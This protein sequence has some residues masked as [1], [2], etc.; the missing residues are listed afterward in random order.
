MHDGPS[1]PGAS[2]MYIGLDL[3]TTNIKALLLD[4]TGKCLAEADAPVSLRTPAAD[5]VEQDMSEIVEGAFR[6]L[7]ACGK[8]AA[9]KVKA[10]GVS[11]QGGA[12][13][14]VDGD[15]RPAGPVIGWMDSRAASWEEALT[16]ELGP[17]WF[18]VHT[19]H[20]RARGAVGQILRLRSRSPGL[21][22]PPNGLGFVGD[23]AVQ[24]L[25]G[26]R[27][28]D[29]TSLSIAGLCNPALRDVD[30]DLLQK[31]GLVPDR[32]PRL[33][34]A[35][36]PAG[37]LTRRAAA[38]TGLVE[39]TPVL[40]A[41][42][43]QYAAAV[44]AGVLDPGDV[45]VGAGTAWVLLAVT[46]RPGTPAAG[47]ALVGP[48][49]LP[50][51][52]GQMLAPG[53]GGASLEW[54]LRLVGAGRMSADELDARLER[55]PP[56]SDGVRVV[57]LFSPIVPPGLSPDIRGCIDG[58]RLYHGADHLLRAV[59]E[60]LAC[61]L[62]RNVRLLRSAGIDVRRLVLTGG[63]TVSRVTPQI[64]ADVTG[65]PVLCM[66]RTA[67]SAH[68]AAVLARCAAENVPEALP[69]LAGAMAP[70]AHTVSPGP[71]R[72]TGKALA[73]EYCERVARS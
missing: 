3:G 46:D 12:V 9:G 48:H 63:A 37:G 27:A 64:I 15:G 21:L 16:R 58:V 66:E 65:L 29:A 55:I 11:A 36:Q 52:W 62:E 18:A 31:L 54:C 32:L 53:N 73:D 22:D 50:G 49:V 35:V 45:M 20:P 23:V 17:A 44:G 43:D 5:A 42:H 10:I 30:P 69:D 2:M 61:E 33:L 70:Q 4:E 59:I 28:H 8:A 24:F 34:S 41:V 25:C 14:V 51:R 39:G 72:S 19:G 7:E 67:M 1:V 60:G 71:G 40:P 13:Q 6:V 26:V 68:G 57:P 47:A 38:R 56:G